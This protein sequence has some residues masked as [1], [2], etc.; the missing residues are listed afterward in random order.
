MIMDTGPAA[1]LGSTLD[2]HY[3]EPALVLNLGNGHTI[4]A[5][6]MDGR[7]TAL[8]EHHTSAMT[9]ERLFA[10]SKGLSDGTLT[11]A[12]VFE[13]GGHGAHVEEAPGARSIGS[14]MVTGPNRGLILGSDAFWPFGEITPAAPG[15]DMM[16]SGCLGLIEA[17]KRL[18]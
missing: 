1:L 3:R 8:F 15:G 2:P 17:W 16:T 13:D 14:V 7:I 11:N 9:P 6:M 4:G 12:Q 5:V 10:F 18:R